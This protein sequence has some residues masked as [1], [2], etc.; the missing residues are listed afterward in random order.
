MAVRITGLN[1]LKSNFY[2]GINI[3]QNES[4]YKIHV[5]E[6]QMRLFEKPKVQQSKSQ[7][8]KF[9]VVVPAFQS[10]RNEG[11][12]QRVIGV[13][14]SFLQYTSINRIM[15]RCTNLSDSYD[16]VTGPRKLKLQIDSPLSKTVREMAFCKYSEDRLKFLVRNNHVK[17]ITIMPAGATSYELYKDSE[18]EE[19]RLYLLLGLEETVR[20]EKEFMQR[21]IVDKLNECGEPAIFEYGHLPF[22]TKTGRY[23][24]GFAHLTCDDLEI[25]IYSKKELI[26]MV[27]ELVDKH[28]EELKQNKTIQFKMEGF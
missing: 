6:T 3:V 14:S 24:P 28:N 27:Q 23:V 11:D 1:L 10:I 22:I 25:D 12:D 5:K 21:I 13:I 20:Q 2:A 15:P 19:I 17:K 9:Q 7:S 18:K 4:G 8:S 16:I 26:D